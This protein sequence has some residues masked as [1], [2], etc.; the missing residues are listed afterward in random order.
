MKSTKLQITRRSLLF[1]A[2][3]IIACACF[4]NSCGHNHTEL[5]VKGVD[6]T[7]EADGF[8]DKIICAECGEVLKEGT[9][10]PAKGHTEKIIPEIKATCSEN[11]ATEG[12]QCSVCNQIIV[13][14]TVILAKHTEEII[15]GIDPG[16]GK[17][18]YTEGKKCTECKEIL[19]SPC[20]ITLLEI[21]IDRERSTKGQIS[22]N[23]VFNSLEGEFSVY[24]GN[25]SKERLPYYNELFTIDS[26]SSN[27]TKELDSLIIPS[28]CE[29][30][31]A[32]DGSDYV[33][34][35]K[36]PKDCLLGEKDYTYSS[37]SDIHVNGGEN[38]RGKYFDGALDFLDKYGEI[39]FVAISGDVSDDVESDLIWFNQAISDR[40]YKVYTTT[41][42]HD[43][44][45][46]QSGRWLKYMNTTI[47]TDDEVFDIG[48]NG[49]DFVYIPK[50]N[51]D[52][53][54]VFL[55]QTYWSYPINPTGTEYSILAEEQIQWLEDVLEKYKDKTVLLYFH[56]FLSSPEGKQE[57]AVGNLKN[58][59]GYSYNL[60]FSYGTADEIAFRALMKKYKNVIF[61][62]GHSHWMFEMEK[63]NA[64]LNVSNFGGEYCYM[65]HNPSVS[66]PRWIGE[67]DTRRTSKYGTNSEGWIV[68]IYEDSMVLIPVDFLSETFYTEYMKIIP[69]N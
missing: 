56:T 21:E 26:A 17:T 58:P 53:V 63:Y 12:K 42:N 5:A 62:S 6:A 25:S 16:V 31:I 46:L 36:L 4:F 64:N 49:L 66:E 8:T 18:G 1:I 19:V 67:N 68:E 60:P 27:Y 65:V 43:S 32:N 37:L 7:C 30:I 20:E 23:L 48:K 29:Y 52:S 54:F 11:G 34:F 59:G 41:G 22:G 35:A 10:I 33:Y 15:P 2:I 45:N 14:P 44:N 3:L 61:F 57:N 51:P 69:L 13:E 50:K 38:S 55:C 28:D 9:V 47:T 40:D 39:D 24:Y